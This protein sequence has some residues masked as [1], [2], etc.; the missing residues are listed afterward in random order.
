MGTTPATPLPTPLVKDVRRLR[1]R[2]ELPAQPRSMWV[3]RPR[4]AERSE[5]PDLAQRLVLGEDTLRLPRG[6]GRIRL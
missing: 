3:E 1:R 4:P 6:Q 2:R 5:A